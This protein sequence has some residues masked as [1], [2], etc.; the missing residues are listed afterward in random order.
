[1]AR[2]T[3]SLQLITQHFAHNGL[4]NFLEENEE[5]YY[6]ATSTP[7]ICFFSSTKV[8]HVE[9]TDIAKGKV[10]FCQT[11]SIEALATNFYFEKKTFLPSLLKNIL[12]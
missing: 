6:L 12:H 11:V 4:V 3:L 9:S 7:F 10:F 2:S 1:L 8:T 5:Q